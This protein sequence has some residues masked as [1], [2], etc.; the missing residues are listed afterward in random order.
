M[1]VEYNSEHMSIGLQVHAILN[2]SMVALIQN[3]CTM[4]TYRWGNI[5]PEVKQ[6]LMAEILVNV[7]YFILFILFYFFYFIFYLIL[8]IILIIIDNYLI[9]FYTSL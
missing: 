1:N 9:H 5:S 2:H 3:R 8:L 7:F 6:G 4:T